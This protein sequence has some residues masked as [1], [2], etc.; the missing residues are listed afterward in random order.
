MRKRMKYGF[1]VCVLGTAVMLVLLY[2]GMR[3]YVGQPDS[4]IRSP[5]SSS[6]SS[7]PDGMP[8]AV[9]EKETQF[10]TE[11]S[12]PLEHTEGQ[13]ETQPR[14]DTTAK[15]AEESPEAP[16]KGRKVVLEDGKEIIVIDEVPDSWKIETEVRFDEE[17]KPH[18]THR[19]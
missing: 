4:S 1:F 6:V 17:G 3:K 8:E 14:P 2:Y 18:V 16:I 9:Q 19:K 5:D 11:R 10:P 13:L 7:S 12:E 15:E